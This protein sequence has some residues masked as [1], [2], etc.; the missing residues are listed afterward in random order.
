MRLIVKNQSGSVTPKENV[1]SNQA[2]GPTSLSIP[3]IQFLF[4]DGSHTIFGKKD[5]LAQ[6]K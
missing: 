2:S 4:P 6:K 5:C 1:Y 3:R